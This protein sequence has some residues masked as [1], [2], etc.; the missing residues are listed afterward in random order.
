MLKA[1][2]VMSAAVM[3]L[4]VATPAITKEEPPPPLPVNAAPDKYSSQGWSCKTGFEEVISKQ[5]VRGCEKPARSVAIERKRELAERRKKGVKIGMS[6]DEVR[7]SSWGRPNS[8]NRT[9]TSR[10]TH[11]Q[12]VYGGGYLYFED[13]IL[14]TVQN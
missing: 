12:W 2:F 11:E 6:Q 3:L 5:Q 10:G 14:T 9:S 8:V 13:G 1:K 7:Q 4:A